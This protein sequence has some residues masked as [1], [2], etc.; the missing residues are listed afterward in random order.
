M[1][2][3]V[4]QFGITCYVEILTRKWCFKIFFIPLPPFKTGRFHVQTWDFGFLRELRKSGHTDMPDGRKL[5]R[6]ALLRRGIGI[7]S[8]LASTWLYLLV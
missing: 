7:L 4:T 5:V 1:V 8:T 2:L 6:V 3:Y